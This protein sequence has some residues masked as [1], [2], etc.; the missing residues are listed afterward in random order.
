VGT[1]FH[2]ELTGREN[3]YLNGA[4]L[5][6]KKAEIERK[7]DEI[8]DFAEIE[9]FLDTPVKRYSSGMYVRLAFAVAAHLEPEILLVD[10]VLAVGDAEFQKKCMGKMGSV[11]KEGRTVLFVSHNLQAVESLCQKG[12]C[13]TQG[14]VSFEG[15][16]FDAVAHY[17]KSQNFDQ[18]HERGLETLPRRTDE[19][20]ALRLT[21]IG[22]RFPDGDQSVWQPL[23]FDLDVRCLAPSCDT[24]PSVEVWRYDGTCAFTCD[25]EDGGLVL[26]LKQGMTGRVSVDIAHP[27]LPPGKYYARAV[28]R[29][30]GRRVLDWVDQ[31][32]VFDVYPIED[33]SI[34]MQEKHLGLRPRS[35]W[36]FEMDHSANYGGIR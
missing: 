30:G 13:L 10:E 25:A 7:F 11:A 21:R 29:S 17:L 27:N 12:I 34:R 26:H 23:H 20:T 15:R 16:A 33:V 8:V 19:G 18:V 31:A 14:Q 6:M 28:A 4:V 9:R 1:G 5:G 36:N 35:Q 3:I 22:V 32:L 24:S 2:P